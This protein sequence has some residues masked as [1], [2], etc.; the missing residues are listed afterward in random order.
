MLR[1][2][3]QQFGQQRLGG[4]GLADG[5]GMD[6]DHGPLDGR[7]A[8][9]EAFTPVAAVLRLLPAASQQT[10]QHQGRGQAEQQGVKETDH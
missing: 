5:N 2:P 7:A 10:Q 1:V 6:P 4:P 3:G 9:A 8:K